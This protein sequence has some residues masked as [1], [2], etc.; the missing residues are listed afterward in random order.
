M[1]P[2]FA[3]LL[4]LILT[5][6]CATT[7]DADFVA[8]AEG[9]FVRLLRIRTAPSHTTR[10]EALMERCVTAAARGDLEFPG[11]WLCYREP[12]GRYWVVTFAETRD[13]FGLPPSLSGFLAGLGALATPDERREMSSLLDGLDHTTEWEVLMRQRKSWS[14]VPGID[15]AL[16]PKARLMQRS[17][18]PG[19]EDAFT[20]AL[21]ARTA[22]LT[23]HDYPLPIEGFVTLEGDPTQAFQLVFPRDWVSFHGSESFSAFVKALP[24]AAQEDY[25]ARKK[26]LMETMSRA[27]FHDASIV[28]ELSFQP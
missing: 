8:D 6:G 2:L 1:R 21:T 23:E 9:L 26:A 7:S 28:A 18:R 13:G 10:F 15:T 19:H 12:P 25:A 17:V 27:E 4:P 16:H 14:T 24:P 5:A 3:V 11:A 20:E 22:F